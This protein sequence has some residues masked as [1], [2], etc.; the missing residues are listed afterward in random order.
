MHEI[1]LQYYIKEHYQQIGFTKL[2]GPYKIGADFKG[3]Y[4]GKP[5]K[6]EVEWD[7]SDYISHKHTTGFADILVV[8]TLEPV[9]EHL[10]VKLPSTII[11]LNCEQVIEW[12]QPRMIKKNKEDY[13][14]YAWRRLS[15]NLLFLY[16]YYQKQT[17]RRMDYIG[18]NLA[19]S[20]NRSQKPGGFKFGSGGKEE[21]FEGPP[22]DKVSWDCWLNV[23]HEVANHFRLKP[24]LLR[25]TW[26]DMLA[27]YFNHTGRITDNEFTRFKDIAVFIDGLIL[28]EG[29]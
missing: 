17:T 16:A 26:I 18:S 8:A 1:W 27:L 6:I 14:S 15:R 29:K 10:K 2:N 19:I 3:V 11:N 7:Y 23:A 12:A 21:S 28:L 22:E 4:A 13:H 9:P 25:P 5:V 24:A 20:M